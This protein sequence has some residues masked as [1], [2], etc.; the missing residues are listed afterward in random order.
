MLLYKNSMFMV[1]VLFLGGFRDCIIFIV[2]MVY[3]HIPENVAGP[4]E[5]SS[6]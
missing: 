1:V 2:L 4:R 5:D 6:L 3:V